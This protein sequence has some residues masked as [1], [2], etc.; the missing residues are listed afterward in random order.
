MLNIVFLCV[1]SREMAK[2][3]RTRD[4]ADASSSSREDTTNCRPRLSVLPSEGEKDRSKENKASPVVGLKFP[5]DFCPDVFQKGGSPC[6]WQDFLEAHQVFFAKPLFK[7]IL[8][9]F[10]DSRSLSLSL[11]LSS[12]LRTT[13]RA[14]EKLRVVIL[15]HLLRVFLPL[16]S[17]L[18]T[19]SG[20]GV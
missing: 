12:M 6:V 14:K 9:L 3:R 7:Y 11:V 5:M 2:R 10:T 8:R 16:D 13:E 20:R 1:L 4:I 18:A 17:V 15:V 19:K